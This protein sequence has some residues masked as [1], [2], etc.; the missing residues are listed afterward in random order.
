MTE[1]ISFSIPAGL[2]RKIDTIR[3]DV[4]RSRYIVKLLESAVS[5][6]LK[7]ESSSASRSSEATNQQKMMRGLC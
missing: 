1:V 6:G 5:K 2:R 3:G 7:I 4:P